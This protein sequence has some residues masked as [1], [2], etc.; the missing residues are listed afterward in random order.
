MLGEL[1]AARGCGGLLGG[2]WESW[3]LLG[4]SGRAGDVGGC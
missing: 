1:G 3:G 2:D 4:A